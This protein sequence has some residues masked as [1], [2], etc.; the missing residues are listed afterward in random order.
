MACDFGGAH[1]RLRA[2]HDILGHVS[3]CLGVDGDGRFAAWLTRSP[4]YRVLDFGNVEVPG[5]RETVQRW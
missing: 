2:V 3:A 5:Y 4:S 1:D